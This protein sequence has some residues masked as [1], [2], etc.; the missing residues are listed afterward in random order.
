[1]ARAAVRAKQLERAKA[2]PTKSRGRKRRHSGGGNPNQELFFVKMRRG[3]KWLYGFLAVVFAL[4]FVGVGVGSGTGGLQQLYSGLFGTGGNPVSKARSEI[5]DHPAQGYRDLATA[6]ETKSQNVLAAAA[7]TKYLKLKK[8]DAGSWAE[9]GGLELTQAQKYTGQYSSAQTA[10]QSAD[11]SAPF[12]PG[13]TLGTAVGTNA[14]Y[15]GASQ[16]ASTRVSTI[17]RKAIAALNSS[18]S[19]Y[20]HATKSAP[21]N[22]SYWEELATASQNAGNTTVAIHALKMYLRLLPHTPLKKQIESEIK[23]LEK[24]ATSASTG[25]GSGGG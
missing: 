4:T 3:Q 12:L 18:V 13:G 5:K 10:A 21:R 24:N 2:Q 22:A 23:A 6:Y 7:L 11:P 19:D 17:Y 25:T 15:Q 14:A 1:M 9:L 8:T 16:N 20:E